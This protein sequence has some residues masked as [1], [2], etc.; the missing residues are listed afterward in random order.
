MV[1]EEDDVYEVLK[2]SYPEIY[3]MAHGLFDSVK[4]V[5]QHACGWLFGTKDRPLKDWVPLTLIASSGRLVTQYNMSMLEDFGLNKGD[6]LRLRTL[7]VI[8]NTRKMVGQDGLDIT[9]IPLDDP[10][11]FELLR[12]GK[13]EGIFTLQ[14]KRTDVAVSR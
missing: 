8:Q 10:K 11:T 12:E 3:E 7:D 13:T 14:G 1:D 5:S 4:N 6:F 2:E 9:D